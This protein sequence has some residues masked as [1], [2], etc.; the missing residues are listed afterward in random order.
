M[1][2]L[3]RPIYEFDQDNDVI[4]DCVCDIYEHCAR[5]GMSDEATDL[6]VQEFLEACHNKMA[7]SSQLA[8]RAAEA[9]FG[10]GIGRC[11]RRMPPRRASRA[12]SSGAGFLPLAPRLGR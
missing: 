8:K 5:G 10:E 11:A 12:R 6:H 1:A 4:R 2:T 9:D 7:R 3:R